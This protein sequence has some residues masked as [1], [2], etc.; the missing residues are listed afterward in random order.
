MG[1]I[2]S[3]QKLSES[4]MERIY[5][6]APEMEL[7]VADESDVWKSHLSDA[8]VI[9]GW[10]SLI[11]EHIIQPETKLRWIQNWGAGVNHFPFDRL[12]KSGIVLTNT[13]GVHAFPIAE[14]IFAMVLSF[15]RKLNTSIRNQINQVWKSETADEI[16]GK[17]ISIIGVGAIGKETAKIAKAFGMTVW[18]VSY[19]GRPVANV[20]K[21]VKRN[22]LEEALKESDFIVMTV[23]LT[24]ET[25]HMIGEKEFA[26]MKPSAMYINIGR[27]QTTDEKALAAALQSGGIAGAGLDVFEQEPLP[28]D[29]PL[30]KMDNVIVS[31]HHA[32]ATVQYDERAVEI[33]LRNL[34]D[35]IAGREPSVNRVDLAKQY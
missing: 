21:I 1:K 7:I 15:T 34:E 17:T 19:S 12:A 11:A 13:S 2:I 14:T 26:V 24:D 30:W 22:G 8:E 4:H 20:D 32:G 35:F 3:F 18:G 33:F 6:A 10:H 28:A 27:G 16:H 9:I 25:R 31:P 23:P 5:K 29:S